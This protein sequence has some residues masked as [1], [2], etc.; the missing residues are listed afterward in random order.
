MAR[1]KAVLCPRGLQKAGVAPEVPR[2]LLD[3]SVAPAFELLARPP[4]SLAC[5]VQDGETM[6]REAPGS[7]LKANQPIIIINVIQIKMN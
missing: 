5:I 3:P 1:L 2:L 4:P 6:L 7:K